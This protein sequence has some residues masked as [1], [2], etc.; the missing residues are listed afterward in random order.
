MTGS[1]AR[2]ATLVTGL[3]LWCTAAGAEPMKCSGEHQV[4]VKSCSTLTDATRLRTCVTNCSQRQA[5]CRQTG[6]WD[7]GG[8]TYC[9]LLRQ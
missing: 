3:L 9:G 1:I 4:C 8:S 2:S 6:C 5:A 7:N